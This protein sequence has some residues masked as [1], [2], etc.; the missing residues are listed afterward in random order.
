[1][2]EREL[3]LAIILARDT[4]ISAHLHLVSETPME[5]VYAITH[6]AE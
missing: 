2:L 1:M 5:K 3:V 4:L 6:T